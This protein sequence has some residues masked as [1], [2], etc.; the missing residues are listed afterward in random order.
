MR[1]STLQALVLT[2]AICAVLLV[3][4]ASRPADPIIV[5][6]DVPVAVPVNCTP[7]INPPDP[8]P[9]DSVSTDANV[10][11]LAKA[12]AGDRA[13]LIVETLNLRAALKGCAGPD[14]AAARLVTP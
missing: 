5:T 4:C 11:D 9:T 10:F 6:R 1:I 2:A 3:A 7:D 13:L 8:K 14:A 12:F